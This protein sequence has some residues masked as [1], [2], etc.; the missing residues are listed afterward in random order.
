MTRVPLRPL[1]RILDAR[2][3]GDDPDAIEREN[4]HLRHEEMRDRARLRAEGRLLVLAALFFCAFITVGVRMG[5]LSATEPQEPR[6]QVGGAQ[7][8][9]TRGDIID[10]NGNLLATN[11]LTHAL[12]AQPPQM[13]DP[14]RAA[15][16]LVAIFPDLKEEK[17][18]ADFT[19]KR[20]FLWIKKKISP[21]QLQAV[22]DIGEPGLLFAPR[23]MRLYP[24]GAI[25]SHV[26]GGARFGNEGVHAAELVGTAGIERA[27]NERLSDPAQ[28]G[29]PLMLTL[30]LTVQAAVER[31][32]AGG[33]QMMGAKGAAAVLMD[34]H[35]GEIVSIASLPDFDPNDRPNPL[36]QGQPS[37]SPLFNRAVQ[38][39][40]ELGSTFKIFASAQALELGLVTPDTMINT[41]GPLVWG[42]HRI[43]DFHDYGAQLSV[44][45]VIV[46]SSNIG[47]A[48]LAKMIGVSR[49]QQFLDSL[50]FFQPTPVEL[51]EATGAKPLLPPNW[52]ELSTITISYG[53]GLSASP[54]HLAT[55]YSSILNGGTRVTPTLLR[56][57]TP[58][59]GPRV[60]SDLTSAQTREMLRLVVSS[61]DG[62]ASFG[63]V[64]GYNVGGKTG[65]A[66]K[67]R[68]T[69]GYYD[70]KVI[71]TFASVFPADD[72][73]YV[74][75]VALD[76]PQIFMAGEMRRTA[77][78]TAVPVAAEIIKRVAPLL[79]LKP[80][81][82][83]LAPMGV[84]LTSN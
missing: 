8:V 5:M 58:T 6:A 48:N 3:K 69:G 17:L 75:V 33:M 32:L 30:D 50:G 65:T 81:I 51:V 1:A 28:A 71:G 29:E 37:D 40:Y 47:T 64:P 79:G 25:A 57:Q 14:A 43:R 15:K 46:M 16:E 63:E 20:K 73:Q 78:Y 38:G 52:S 18:L 4:K 67:P 19:G 70:D 59:L 10:R 12:Y 74:L 23:E 62:T 22:H 83:P 35:T 54:L 7:I 84:T 45:D 34:V 41:R 55:A 42:K 60:V 27:M 66:N 13:V 82:E 80:E 61:P 77:G 2:A 26:L 31:V 53:H 76:E 9:A 56:A 72:P 11:L 24:N 36:T 39:V 21:E 68:P 44:S 49:Q